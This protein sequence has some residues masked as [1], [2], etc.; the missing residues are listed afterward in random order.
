[1]CGTRTFY[2]VDSSPGFDPLLGR[3][4][5]KRYRLEERIGRG[6]MGTVYRATQIAMNKIVAVKVMNPD[7]ARNNEAARRFH[8]EAKAASLLSHPHAIRVID[9]GQA[10]TRDLFMVMEFLDGRPLSTVMREE[11]PFPLV[12]AAKVGCEI[13]QALAEA[14]AANLVHRDVKPDNVFLLDVAGD[15]DFVKVLDFGIAKFLTGTGDS[16]V[17][18]TGGFVGTPQFMAPEQAEGHVVVTPAIDVYS[19]GVILYSML[20]GQHPFKCDTPIQA[21]MAHLY[22]PIPALPVAICA[23]A[24]MQALLYRMLAKAP[25]DR[26]SA[27]EVVT[28]LER[29][30]LRELSKALHDA[31]ASSA[32]DSSPSDE[33]PSGGE[34]STPASRLGSSRVR[35]AI[36]TVVLALALLGA[37]LAIGWP[38]APPRAIEAPPVASPAVVVPAAVAPAVVAPAVVAPAVPAPEV[39]PVVAPV[40]APTPPIDAPTVTAPEVPPP[41][42]APAPPGSDGAPEHGREVKKAGKPA[43]RPSAKPGARAKPQEGYEEIW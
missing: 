34:A 4:L 18:K 15:A 41:T 9:F 21:V 3:V 23:P 29:V 36:A 2:R 20:S 38:P 1:M 43:R 11:A 16:A 10:A 37:A 8:R 28:S 42:V 12:R 19:L 6:G 40:V 26:P 30:R 17:T 32:S 31:D 13:A 27:V 33:A 35:L 5:E 22:E 25:A 39:A 24:E 14:H 7:L